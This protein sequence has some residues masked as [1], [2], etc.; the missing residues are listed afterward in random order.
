MFTFIYIDKLKVLATLIVG[1]VVVAFVLT[2]VMSHDV[3]LY[4]KSKDLDMMENKH[5]KGVITTKN[6][7]TTR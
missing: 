4:D 7:R 3:G 6:T 5:F 2:V 1:F